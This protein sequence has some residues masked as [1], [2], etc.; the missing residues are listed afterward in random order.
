MEKEASVVVIGG[1]IAGIQASV[2]LADRGYKVH[3]VEKTPSIGGSMVMLD[4]TFPTMDCSICI[5]APKMID[6]YR[7]PNINLLT[8]SEV[9]EVEGSAGDFTVKVLR[10]TRFVD[11]EKCTGCDNCTE[12]CTVTLPNEFEGSLGTRKAIYRPFPQAIPNVFTIDKKGVPLCRVAC[13]GGINVQGYVALIKDGKFEEALELIRTAIPFPAV[14]GKVCF[15]PCEA[16]CERGKVEEPIAI[17]ALKRFVSDY[18]VKKGKEKI[19]PFPRKYDDKVA[20]IGAGPAGLTAAFELVKL[21]YPVTVFE[22]MPEPGGML[23]YGIPPYRLPKEDLDIEIQRIIDSGVEIKTSTQLGKDITVDGLFEDGYKSAFIAIGA[24]DSRGLNVEG[25]E[26]EGVVQAIDYL[27]NVN[28]GKRGLVKGK[29]TVIGGGDVAMDA[30]RSAIRDG[31]EEVSILYRRSRGEMPANP[32]DVEMAE[33]EGV[34]FRFLVNPMRFTGKDGR[35]TGVECLRME[36]GEPDDSGRRRP[37]PIEGSEFLMEADTVI[38]AIGQVP[39]TSSIPEGIETTRWETISADEVTLETSRPGVFAGGDI[40]DGPSTVIEVIGSGKRAAESIDR[41]LR[42]EDLRRGR[43]EP[44]QEVEEVSKEGV[45]PRPREK[46]PKL[47]VVD[48]F[49]NFSEVELGFT[50]EMA[51]REAERCLSCGGCSECLECE[52]ICDPNAIDHQQVEEHVDL[53]VGAIIVATGLTPFDPSGIKEYG[54]GRYQ[55]VITALELER[56][57][58]ATG[59]TTGHLI[60]PSDHSVP[61]KVAF[62]QCVGSRS[63]GEGHQYCSAVCCMHATKEAMLVKEHEPQTEVSIFYTDL[64]AFGK[65]FRELVNRARDRYGVEY[66]RAKPSEIR[67]DP[68]TGEL[69]FWYEDTTTGDMNEVE[70]DL[71]VL[72]TA[73]T[74]N[75]GNPELA[76][77]LGVELDEYGFYKSQNPILAPLDTTREGI[78]VCGYC[79]EPKDIPDSIADASGAAARAAEIVESV[80]IV[81][82]SE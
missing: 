54:Y 19:E 4:K 76:K 65:G 24:Q 50:E 43:D 44:V 10:K 8:Y 40:V 74:P 66:V 61:K 18:E 2:D 6:C 48:R 79:Q 73:L 52:K 13:P 45:E 33:E 63:L 31:C 78:F 56:L 39:D 17:K 59:P 9:K 3:L 11:E 30:A 82:G 1:G 51:I 60:R 67:E 77:I 81:E 5:L 49:G 80:A 41:Y 25:E 29:V 62:I 68:Q 12:V 23:R 20:V 42:G 34:K 35:I 16:E 32:E 46:M 53:N 37:I 36:L 38:L 27:K 22:S 28:M 75:P 55:N 64:R 7:H 70:F 47:Q 69:S 26:L 58:S 14:C 21:G 72:S 71:V 15:H 57:V